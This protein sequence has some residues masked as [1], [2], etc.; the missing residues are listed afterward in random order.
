MKTKQHQIRSFINNNWFVVITVSFV[1]LFIGLVDGVPFALSDGYGYFHTAKELVTNSS[2]VSS[3]TPEYL[4]YS[5]HTI[6]LFND[7]YVTRYSPGN[8]IFW[9]LPL[10]FSSLFNN[11]TIYDNYYKAFNGHS[12]ADGMIVLMTSILVIV[13]N[14]P[15]FEA[16][17]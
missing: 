16:W 10:K 6:S 14:P 1:L 2:F 7:N 5:G 8:S 13:E 17:G 15:G 11:N 4:S 9:F 3:L 12:F